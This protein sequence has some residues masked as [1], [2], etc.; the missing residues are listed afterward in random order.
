MTTLHDIPNCDTVEKTYTWLE[1]D[2]VAYTFHDFRKQGVSVDML[3]G[4]L[5]Y[6]PLATLLNHKGATWRVL[7][8]ADKAGVEDEAGAI[9]LMQASPSLIKRPVLVHG[10]GVNV[11]FPSD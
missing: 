3:A 10:K 8:D 2:D 5:K 11:G 9:A 7:S 1:P 4:W 6:V